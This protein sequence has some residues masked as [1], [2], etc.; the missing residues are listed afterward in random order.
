MITD[1]FTAKQIKDAGVQI[2]LKSDGFLTGF[3]DDD[4]LNIHHLTNL[5]QEKV[6]SYYN[7]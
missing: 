5:A 3:Y 2:M 4:K 1:Y 7:K 6:R